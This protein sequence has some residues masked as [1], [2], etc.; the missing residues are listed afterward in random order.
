MCLLQM[1]ICW[2]WRVLCFI[3]SLRSLLV[4]DWQSRLL[5]IAISIAHGLASSL[6]SLSAWL[7]HSQSP[8]APP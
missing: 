4:L 6:S 2:I 5:L 8:Y 3:L 7:C 1:S